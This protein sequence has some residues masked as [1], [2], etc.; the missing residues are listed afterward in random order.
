MNKT[1]KLLLM[2]LTLMMLALAG[3]RHSA[4]Y[5]RRLLTADSLV[6]QDA[7]QG[8]AFLKS[9]DGREFSG[10]GDRAYYA[11]LLTQAR[12]RC[13]ERA[14]SDSTINLALDYYKEHSDET[15][16]LTRCY[17]F[18]G[19][20]MEELG[21]E[22]EAIINYKRAM[23]V[24]LPDDHYNQGYA[25]LRLGNIYRDNYIAD[26][27]DIRLMR[28]ALHHFEAVPDS[29]YILTCLSGIGGSYGRYNKDSAMN[30]LLRADTL[31]KRLRQRRIEQDNLIYIADI[32]M[33]S[34]DARDID[35]AKGI[36]LSLLNARDCPLGRKDHLLMIAAL[37]L[38]KQNKSDSAA[39]Y[40][41]QVNTRELS[42]GLRI[43]YHTCLAEMAKC[44][45]DIDEFQYQCDLYNNLVDSVA[46]N[47]NQMKLRNIETKYDNQRLENEN[48]RY[49]SKLAISVLLG[50]LIA[51]L[52]T[53]ALMLFWRKAARRKLRLLE[54]E[55]TIDRMHQ[56]LTVLEVQLNSEQEMNDSLKEAIRNQVETFSRLVE[57]HA[58][59]SGE[60]QRDFDK[61]FKETYNAGTL[62]NSF[63]KG[64]RAYADSRLNG[65]IGATRENYP[66]VK[67]SD[68]NFLSLYSLGLSQTVIM[69][70]MGYQDS[71]SFYN[72]KRRLSE[73]M[74]LDN[75][76]D[77]YIK[78]FRR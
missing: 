20:V 38:A 5:D 62:D 57:S 21:Q 34:R 60:S 70:C 71:H 23:T 14:T 46:N 18:K 45:N 16:K 75:S 47:G 52:L 8:L 41:N 11:L 1:M 27:A 43:F 74:A 58:T 68:L 3:C 24:A 40:F 44:R 53:I 4:D 77:G 48:I 66:M 19:A 63:W 76:L 49:R 28:E 39:L 73:K 65:I 17:I 51:S 7:E 13:Y 26:S 29:F 2:I 15:E 56:D 25:R 50:L 64:I 59:T 10:K 6:R 67:E 31:A 36:A 42:D 72:K 61:L 55:A 78:R 35:A 54:A 12:Y 30:Y 33:F 69:A 22:D 37:T 9:M 32:K